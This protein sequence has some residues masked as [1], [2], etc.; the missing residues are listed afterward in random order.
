MNRPRTATFLALLALA[1]PPV[2]AQQRRTPGG[3]PPP[4]ESAPVPLE[5]VL[6]ALDLTP[7]QRAQIDP[8]MTARREAAEAARPAA[9]AAARALADQVRADTFDEAAIREKA[10]AVEPFDADRAVADSALLRDIRAVLA[11][12][13]FEKLDRLLA[14]LPPPPSSDGPATAPST[15]S[16]RATSSAAGLR[17]LR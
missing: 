13:Q 8:L 11:P 7:E 12:E 3:P 14:P 15:T 2:L 16:N 5:F 10:A 9:D 1:I 6:R 4:P 17:S